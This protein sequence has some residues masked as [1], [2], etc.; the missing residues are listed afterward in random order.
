MGVPA[1]TVLNRY[2]ISQ[3]SQT[4]S[5][6]EHS[7]KNSSFLKSSKTKQNIPTA[8]HKNR[9]E[10]E[11]VSRDGNRVKIQQYKTEKSVKEVKTQKNI[12]GESRD[13]TKI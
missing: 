2:D 1:A 6:V 12:R 3:V 10:S 8:N 11:K 9:M 5:E 13:R 7:T 4:I